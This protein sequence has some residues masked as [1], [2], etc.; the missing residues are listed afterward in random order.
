MKSLAADPE[1]DLT[2]GQEALAGGFAGIFSSTAITP[3]EVIKCRLQVQDRLASGGIA[4]SPMRYSGP[5]DAVIKT[6]R[7]E[8]FKGLFSGLPSLWMRDIP[9]NFVFLGSYEAFCTLSSRALGKSREELGP[10]EL[11]LCGGLAGVSGWSI[12]FPMDVVKSK[13]QTNA[14]PGLNSFEVVRHTYRA[15]G[16]RAFYQGWSA[17]VMRAF[18]ANAALLL[19]VE[20]SRRFFEQ[21][22]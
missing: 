6:V 18:P 7:S 10:A 22:S 3:A 8:G 13:V 15:G 2:L 4:N 17:A 14:Y 16:I 11:F 19:G 20:F 12:I 9:F 1:A 21:Y 5:V